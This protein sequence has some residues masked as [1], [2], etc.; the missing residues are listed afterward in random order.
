MWR[1]EKWRT[2]LSGWLRGVARR[3]YS[4]AL[5]MLVV[6]DGLGLM[7]SERGLGALMIILDGRDCSRESK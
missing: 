2:D 7:I 5:A 3:T 6:D 4:R 1:L